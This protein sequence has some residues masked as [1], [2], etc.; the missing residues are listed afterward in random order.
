[1]EALETRPPLQRDS[2]G[3]TLFRDESPHDQVDKDIIIIATAAKRRE[4]ID[5]ISC[6]DKGSL[7]EFDNF[8]LSQ[9]LPERTVKAYKNGKK[10]VLRIAF[11]D[12]FLGV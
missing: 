4:K 6:L 1:M 9:K 8:I 3:R 2:K 12:L 11:Y 10:M 7:K 5:N